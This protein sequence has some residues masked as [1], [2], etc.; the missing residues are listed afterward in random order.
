MLSDTVGFISDLPTELIAAFRATLEEVLEADLLL[1]VRDLSHDDSEAQRQDVTLVLRQ[2]FAGAENAPPIIEVRNK[3]D[4]LPDAGVMQGASGNDDSAYV[5]VSALTG[6]GLPEL[7]TAIET[8]LSEKLLET[9]SYTIA[10]RT[11]RQWLGSIPTRR[12]TARK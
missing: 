3:I 1:H 7:C 12:W 9:R 8:H 10:R 11:A 6:T 5:A 2:L 4:L